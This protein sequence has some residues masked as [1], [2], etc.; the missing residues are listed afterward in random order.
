MAEKKRYNKRQ[1]SL[2]SMSLV[3]IAAGINH[4]WHPAFY[5]NIMPAY[6][7]FPAEMVLISGVCEIVTGILL[8]FAPSRK[9]AAWLIIAMLIVFFTVHVDMIVKTYR[10]GGLPFWIAVLRFPLQ[11]VLIR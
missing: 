2:I 11:F 5:I 1:L 8:W 9:A 10:A 4:F 7:P 6:I 3:Y